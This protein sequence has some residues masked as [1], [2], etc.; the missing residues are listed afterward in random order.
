M[1]V[2]KGV[3]HLH[4]DRKER[5]ICR[6][7]CGIKRASFVRAP[8]RARGVQAKIKVF[9]GHFGAINH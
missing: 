7:N 3:R 9:V 5:F 2:K 6:G 8:V 4:P 1:Q